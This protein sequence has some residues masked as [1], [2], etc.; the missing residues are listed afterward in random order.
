[1]LSHNARLAAI[2]DL[3][4]VLGT[5]V[6]VKAVMMS[7]AWQYA[8]PVSLLAA[9]V[10]ATG[11][12]RLRGKRWADYGLTLRKGWK[13]GLLLLPQAMLSLTVLVGVSLAYQAW[14]AP[15]M[16]IASSAE[17][18]FADIANSPAFLMLW[19]GIAIIHGGFFE[20]MIYRGFTILKLTEVLGGSDG[21]RM[22]VAIVLQAGFFGI[23]HMYYQ[24]LGGALA[25]GLMAIAF[26]LL[27]WLFRRNLWPLVI[28]H[29]TTGTLAMTVR[30]LHSIEAIDPNP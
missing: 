29:A 14:I 3:A 9:T 22:P 20:E 8:G 25:T 24:G 27:F 23:R 15:V 12:I 30:Y 10:L 11:L 26:G 18:R 6:I 19:V 7:V 4:L 21:W 2:L 13:S 5:A 1:M 17:D 28:A 16:P